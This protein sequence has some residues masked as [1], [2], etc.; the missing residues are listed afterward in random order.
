M[1]NEL[2]N[3]HGWAKSE[4]VWQVR[5]LLLEFSKNTYVLSKSHFFFLEKIRAPLILE[6]GFSLPGKSL[7]MCVVT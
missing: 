7:T 3:E 2:N 6:M 5:H 1:M 4:R